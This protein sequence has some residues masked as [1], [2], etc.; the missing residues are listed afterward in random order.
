MSH[1]AFFGRAVT[2]AAALLCA[3]SANAAVT[4]SFEA[5]SV[6]G[7]PNFS[8]SFSYTSPDFVKGYNWVPV[9]DCAITQS[10]P[11]TC[12]D[13]M[14]LFAADDQWSTHDYVAVGVNNN[15]AYYFYFE[16]GAF[17]KV[18]VRET[19]L[20]GAD[21][22]GRITITGAPDVGAG[23][24]PEPATWAMM[25]GGIGAIGGTLRRRRTTVAFA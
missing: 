14:G 11:S 19:V 13:L 22:A 9:A 20:L 25:I 16:K 4:Y 18:G 6:Y 1:T 8:A 2:T 5:F 3:A 17:A 7:D 21:Q 10:S 12:S 23:A 24:V 15:S